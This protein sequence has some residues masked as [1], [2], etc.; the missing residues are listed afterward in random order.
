[1]YERFIV[2]K[3][4]IWVVGFVSIGGEMAV[5]ELGR[6][7]ALGPL[8]SAAGGYKTKAGELKFA[9]RRRTRRAACRCQAG[10]FSSLN[11]GVSKFF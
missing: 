1:V 7:A 11:S 2:V 8:G 3:L 10:A 9:V 6:L 4:E 5:A